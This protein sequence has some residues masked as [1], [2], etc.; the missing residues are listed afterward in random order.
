MV[1]FQYMSDLHLELF[2]GFRIGSQEVRAPYLVLAGDIGD[3]ESDEYADFLKSCAALYKMV[4]VVLGNHEGYR[5]PSWQHAV[6]AARTTISRVNLGEHFQSIVLLQNE[7]FDVPEGVRLL[8][9]TLWSAIQEH[10]RNHVQMMMA[11]YRMIGGFDVDYVNSLHSRDVNWLQKELEG[12][13]KDGVKCL[14]VTHHAPLVKGTSNPMYEASPLNSAF[15]T[16]LSDLIISNA[17]VA[18]VW[19]HGHTHHSHILHV[20]HPNTNEAVASVVSNQRGYASR[21]EEIKQFRVD[22]DPVCVLR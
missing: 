16:D 9:C 8:G 17:D 3:P 14:V 21:R 2:P 11:D 20:R 6:E 10:Q 12:A 4:F 5:K 22:A 13:R 15:C 1:L 7:V 19:V 18:S